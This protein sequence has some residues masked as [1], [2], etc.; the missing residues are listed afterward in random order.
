MGQTDSP[1]TDRGIL[2]ARQV[3]RLVERQGADVVYASPLGR[4]L[5]SARI[6]TENLGIPIIT[7]PAMAELSFG[8]WERKSH[9]EIR[10]TGGRLRLTWDDRP[11]GGESYLDGEARVGPFLAELRERSRTERVLVVGHAGVNRVFLKLWLGL[12]LEQ[13]LLIRFPHEALV[14]LEGERNVQTMMA[15]GESSAGLL[16]GEEERM[17]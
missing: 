5:S 12:E 15:T 2:V 14:I 9:G 3:A 8:S 7:T 11:P 1:L 4:A 10:P 6:Y 13:A 16:M 17:R